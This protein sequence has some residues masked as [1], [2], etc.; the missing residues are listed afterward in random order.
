MRP[1]SLA[2]VIDV[3]TADTPKQAQ[4]FDTKMGDNIYEI[5]FPDGASIE[6]ASR[7]VELKRSEA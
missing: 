6:V 1:G 5:Q 7:W 3:R 2:E 4:Q